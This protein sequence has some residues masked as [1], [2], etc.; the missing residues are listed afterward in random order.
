MKIKL[1]DGL[2]EQAA[3]FCVACCKIVINNLLFESITDYCGTKIKISLF[4]HYVS[5]VKF[6]QTLVY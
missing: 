2:K 3:Y 4:L 6:V 1:D 5:G